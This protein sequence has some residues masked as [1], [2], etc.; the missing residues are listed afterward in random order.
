MMRYN[1]S[2]KSVFTGSLIFLFAC[3]VIAV[4][5]T[6]Y[7]LINYQ[8]NSNSGG[9]T[10]SA[11]YSAKVAV[12]QN[13]AGKCESENYKAGTGYI[14]N[15]VA[16]SD[17]NPASNL[18]EFF[19]YPNPYKPG[20]GGDYDA[21][22]LTFANLTQQAKIEVFNIAGELVATIDKD[23]NSNMYE[24]DVANDAGN[25]LASGVYIYY[26]SNELGHKKS[27]KFAIIK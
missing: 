9:E 11:S 24:W 22:Y 2:K 17:N 8:L 13:F 5:S 15:V 1:M 19:A 20:S 14:P 4:V 16:A 10:S 27:G 23:D 18:V 25:K 3:T 26:V 6:N 21:A 7:R 12:G